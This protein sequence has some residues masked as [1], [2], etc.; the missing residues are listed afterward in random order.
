MPGR[1]H[2][3]L[4][5]R[6]EP[7]LRRGLLLSLLYRHL[8]AKEVSDQRRHFRAVG[9]EREVTGIQQVQFDV[10]EVALVGRRSIGD[11]DLIV[12]PHSTSVAG[13]CLR[14]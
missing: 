4:A 8:A 13:W 2:R 1:T 3:Q 14:K 10:V 6:V 12:F 7:D 5:Q 9:L 11:E